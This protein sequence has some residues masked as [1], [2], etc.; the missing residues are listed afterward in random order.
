MAR[1]TSA[2]DDNH[3]WLYNVALAKGRWISQRQHHQEMRNRLPNAE[4][5]PSTYD[6]E[7]EVEEL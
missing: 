4:F 5:Q 7:L 1:R 6:L 3:T 2:T